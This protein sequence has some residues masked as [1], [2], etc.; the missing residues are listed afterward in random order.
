MKYL[1]LK[2]LN[3]RLKESIVSQTTEGDFSILNDCEN[4]A[5]S[6]IE[7][8]I[9]G[10]YNTEIEFIKIDEGRSPLIVSIA[11]D[12][13]VYELYSRISREEMQALRKERYDNALKQLSEIHKGNISLK[14]LKRDEED[15]VSS[16]TY[17]GSRA[18]IN[19]YDY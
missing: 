6:M 2:D 3:S 14:L 15:S 17:F 19:N 16:N 1:T 13:V 7:G 9:G 4:V 11:L 10:K 5:L 8:S 18:K 12:I